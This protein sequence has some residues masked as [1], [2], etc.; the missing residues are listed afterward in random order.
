MTATQDERGEP[1]VV[2]LV[3][4]LNAIDEGR[5]SFADLKLRIADGKPP[6]T[7]TLRRYLSILADAGFPWY[8][9]R[10]LGTYRFSEGYSLKRLNL[11][12]R[13]LFGLVT[14]KRLGASLGGTLAS[15][16]DDAASKL[17]EIADARGAVHLQTGS[18]LALRIDQV[19]LEPEAERV[20]ETLR[21]AEI[22]RRRVSFKYIDKKGARSERN[23]DPYGFIVSSGRVY[24]VGYDH[25]RADMRVFAVDNVTAPR[26]L[27]NRFERPAD[28]DLNAFGAHSLSGRAPFDAADRGDGSILADRRQGGATRARCAAKPVRRA[29]RRIARNRL[30]GCGSAR[31]RAMVARMGWRS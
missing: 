3:R 14:L 10:R 13:E 21:E 18:S 20:F 4:L 9:D 2:L 31:D 12:S 19:V 11:S 30:R 8:F 26:I 22:A 6:S 24:L 15:A 17:V 1:K 28:F 5:H 29:E 27:P 23:V 7:R 25:T 16:I